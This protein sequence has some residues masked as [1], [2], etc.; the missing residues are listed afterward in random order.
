MSWSGAMAALETNLDLAAADAS[1]AIVRHGEP[2]ILN[3]DTLA[4]WAGPGSRVSHTGGNTL[5]KVNI[6]RGA[7]VR[8]YLFG[9]DRSAAVAEA[10]ELRLVAIE[11]AIFT[12]LWADAGLGGHAIGIDIEG[13]EYGWIDV[14]TVKART[15]ELVVWIDL[16]EVAS[17]AL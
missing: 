15:L 6:E 12:R 7:T 11:E 8:A 17:I 3:G 1:I 2:D 4:Y 9:T 5:S 13:S 14:G 10:W 16:A